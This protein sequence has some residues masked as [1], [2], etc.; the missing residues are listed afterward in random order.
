MTRAVLSCLRWL[1]LQRYF[2]MGLVVFHIATCL[3]VWN[4]WRRRWARSSRRHRPRAALYLWYTCASW[5][6]R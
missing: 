1:V 6:G 3:Y 5:P 2:Y 4:H